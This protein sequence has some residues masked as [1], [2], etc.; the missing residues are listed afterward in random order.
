MFFDFPR[1]CLW[2]TKKKQTQ[3][4]AIEVNFKKRF[5]VKGKCR[6]QEKKSARQQH[7]N[8]TF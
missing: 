2:F 6:P 5:Y 3:L 7:V 8:I 1:G 4:F